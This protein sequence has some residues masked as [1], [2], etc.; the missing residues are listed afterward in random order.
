MLWAHGEK[1]YYLGRAWWSRATHLKPEVVGG[2]DKE[3]DGE[4]DREG[5]RERYQGRGPA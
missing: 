5:N 2:G 1:E 3:R 4:K